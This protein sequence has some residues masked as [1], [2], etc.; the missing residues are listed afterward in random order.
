[1]A[2]TQSINLIKTPINEIPLL[3]GMIPVLK[4]M[5]F[6]CLTSLIISGL[7]AGGVYY[8][9]FTLENTRIAQK[10]ALVESV[11]QDSKKEGLLLAVKQRAAIVSS[12]TAGQKNISAFFNLLTQF[13]TP[14]QMET[15]TMSDN[16]KVI[17]GAN[18]ATIGDAVTLVDALLKTV[19]AG[20]VSKPDLVLFNLAKNGGFKISVSFVPIL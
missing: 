10:N 1:M 19:D 13:I 11:S 3:A 12:L 17:I 8:Y 16:N 5:A 15:I 14:E 20:K 18:T 9:F 7:A 4:R 6:I 2:T